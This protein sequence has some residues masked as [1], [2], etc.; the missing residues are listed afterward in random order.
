MSRHLEK[1]HEAGSRED[2][3]QPAKKLEWNVIH[4]QAPS[5]PNLI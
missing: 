2:H 5:H 4:V 1:Q 3:A